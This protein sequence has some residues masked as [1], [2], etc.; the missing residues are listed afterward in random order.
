MKLLRYMYCIALF[1]IADHVEGF[2][3]EHVYQETVEIDSILATDMII[4]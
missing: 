1:C 2:G 4:I 3:E